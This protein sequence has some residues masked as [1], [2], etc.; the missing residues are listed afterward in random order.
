[1]NNYFEKFKRISQNF[2]KT[3]MIVLASHFVVSDSPEMLALVCRKS[4]F[5]LPVL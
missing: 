2:F 1:M 4:T 5:L 3:K